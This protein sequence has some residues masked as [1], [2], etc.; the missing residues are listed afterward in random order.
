MS[1]DLTVPE[2]IRADERQL[3]TARRGS[4]AMVERLLHSDFVEITRSGQVLDRT[5]V[6]EAIHATVAE[7]PIRL[8]EWSAINLEGR[9]LLVT[10]R[11]DN[12][13]TRSRHASVWDLTARQPRV[14]FHQVSGAGRTA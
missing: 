6:V 12:G 10:Y 7:V 14:R 11:A 5:Q 4:E 13:I 2:G 1:A 9:H 8:D 3:L